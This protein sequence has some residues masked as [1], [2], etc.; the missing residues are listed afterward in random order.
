MAL[1]AYEIFRDIGQKVAIEYMPL[2]KNEFV[3]IFPRKK[4]L[5]VYEVKDR[6]N[7]EEYLS[8]YGFKIQNKA[9]FPKVK[10]NSFSRK[11][12][13]QLIL[14]NYESLK[15]MLGFLYKNLKDARDKKR[16]GFSAT[17]DKDPIRAEREM[18]EKV[19][20]GLEDRLIS[21]DM[22]K[23]EIVYLTGGW[24]EE[25][26]F[27]MVYEL[28]QEGIL[29]DSM[30]GVNIKSLSGVQNELDIA[31]MKDNVFYHIECKTLGIEGEESIIRDEVYKKGAISV[32]LGKGENRAIICTTHNQL[33]E[34]LAKRAKDYGVDVLNIEQVRNLRNILL[35]RF[36]VGK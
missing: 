13:S 9:E 18:L 4:P 17:F 24:F 3:Q 26:V 30:T 19:G 5:K 23:D 28:V 36:S 34:P 21:K 25:C 15:G 7:L 32:L 27:N 31:F 29:D 8:G 35:E 10:S 16:Y 14:D 2:G 1:A 11:E 22:P 12:T 6:L 33:K 20:F